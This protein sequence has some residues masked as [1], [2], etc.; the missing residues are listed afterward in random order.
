MKEYEGVD[1]MSI[2][3]FLLY[4]AY[5]KNRL[6]V[7]MYKFSTKIPFVKT[8]GKLTLEFQIEE[9]GNSVNS[10]TEELIKFLKPY[11][12]KALTKEQV[13]RIFLDDLKKY[14]IKSDSIFEMI[15]T[16]WDEI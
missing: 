16:Y 14:N 7:I 15:D 13:W 2:V 6:K 10:T 5:N 11:K 12:E 9:E 1:Y 4:H 3:D 8:T